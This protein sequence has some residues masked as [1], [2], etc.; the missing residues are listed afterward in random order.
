MIFYCE[1]S[2]VNGQQ[3]LGMLFSLAETQSIAEFFC[4]FFALLCVFA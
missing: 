4:Y 2:A 1:F 3:T